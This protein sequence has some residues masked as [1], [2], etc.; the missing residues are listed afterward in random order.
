MDFKRQK[1]INAV[2][3]FCSHT[4]MCGKTKLVKL[5]YYLDFMH[6][7]QTAKSVTDLQYYAW[8][9]GPYP[10][11][12]GNEID[13]PPADLSKALSICKLPEKKSVTI[14]C[15][16]KFNKDVFSQREIKL[17]EQI[18]F[19][20]QE[21]RAEDMV[22]AS[23]LPNHPWDKT[24]KSKGEKA[25]IDY[26]LALDNQKGSI[27]LEEAQEIIHDRMILRELAA[28]TQR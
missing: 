7:R 16:S 22:E 3:Y 10:V 4:K 20:F 15:K 23:H 26:I 8:Q 21:A 19:I 18:A 11:A 27:S 25:A 9:F 13:N 17:L 14:K 6:F 2:I 28:T 12:F 5:L 1:L 24:L